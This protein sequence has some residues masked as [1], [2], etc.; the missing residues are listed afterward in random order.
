MSLLEKIP[1]N[2]IAFLKAIA[3]YPRNH[4]KSLNIFSATE[5]FQQQEKYGCIRFTAHPGRGN[6]SISIRDTMYDNAPPAEAS[7][8]KHRLDDVFEEFLRLA[9]DEI[10]SETKLDGTMEGRLLE[11]SPLQGRKHMMMCMLDDCFCVLI[12]KKDVT[13]NDYCFDV[14]MDIRYYTESS[15]HGFIKRMRDRFGISMFDCLD[16]YKERGGEHHKL[17][18]ILVNFILNGKIQPICYKCGKLFNI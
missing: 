5:R 3:K 13:D 18:E 15:L 17:V 6:C 2:W 8:R 16:N 11:L 9:R 10:L 7:G 4:E 1:R 12:V 14:D